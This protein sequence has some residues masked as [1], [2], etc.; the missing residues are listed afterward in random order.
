MG[1]GATVVANT[2]RKQFKSMCPDSES[3]QTNKTLFLSLY[4]N[5]FTLRK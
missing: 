4:Y 2:T 1:T 5:K 3:K